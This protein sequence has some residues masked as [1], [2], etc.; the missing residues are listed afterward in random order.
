MEFNENNLPTY[1]I[2]DEFDE[3]FDEVFS[4]AVARIA[5]FNCQRKKESGLITKHHRGTK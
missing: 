2:D 5:L 3:V 1:T 4:R